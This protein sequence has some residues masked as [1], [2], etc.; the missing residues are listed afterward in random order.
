MLNEEEKFGIK[1]FKT[2]KIFGEKVYKIR[3]NIRKNLKK[4]K[5]RNTK[6]IGYGAPAKVTTFCHVF[7]LGSKEIKYITDDNELKQNKFTPGKNIK[8]IN[9]NQLKKID[10]DFIIILNDFSFLIKNLLQ[11]VWI[12][13]YCR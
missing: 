9:F 11:T 12:Y 8:I 4:L 7:N 2:Y 13:S 3:E 6:I 5:N 1:K 10:F